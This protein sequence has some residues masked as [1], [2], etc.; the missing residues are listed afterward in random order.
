M[1]G[2]PEPYVTRRE[3]DMLRVASDAEH[4]KIWQRLESMDDH[5]T[6][7]VQGLT[8][9]MDTMI[10]DLADLKTEVKTDVSQLN[11]DMD[12]RFEA[13]QRVHDRDVADRRSAYRWRVM[14]GVTTAASM[15][16]VLGLLIDLLGKVH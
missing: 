10:S 12:A 2:P 4:A 9:R 6:R 11:R 7:G 1:T 8:I 5:G 14:V 16:A 15:A 3:V 13:H